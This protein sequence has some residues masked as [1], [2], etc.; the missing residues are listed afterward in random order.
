[1]DY[2]KN[3]NFSSDRIR[4]FASVFL[5]LKPSEIIFSLLQ[6]N[7]QSIHLFFALTLWI[8]TTHICV[9]NGRALCTAC[10]VINLNAIIY[11]WWADSSA[12]LALSAQWSG[13]DIDDIPTSQFEKQGYQFW[14]KNGGKMV[15]NAHDWSR[16]ISRLRP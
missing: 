12:R 2:L 16:S 8:P 7:L 14:C 11:S 6:S 1:L 15:H 3:T 9:I 5:Y 10:D 4:K 13:L